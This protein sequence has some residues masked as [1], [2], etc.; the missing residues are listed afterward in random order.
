MANF[1]QRFDENEHVFTDTGFNALANSFTTKV[2]IVHAQWLMDKQP[3]IVKVKDVQG[4][5]QR[6]AVNKYGW[7]DSNDNTNR[8]LSSF[9]SK[10]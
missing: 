7:I 6:I 1:W 5:S 4:D 2:Q 10:R 3:N 8:C 9:G